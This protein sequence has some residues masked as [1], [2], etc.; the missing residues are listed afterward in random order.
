[1]V[2]ESREQIIALEE[3]ESFQKDVTKMKTKGKQKHL[4]LGFISKTYFPC[5]A[6]TVSFS[7]IIGHF[8]KS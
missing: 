6:S 3:F 5:S 1:M 8:I 2:C 7:L 4:L